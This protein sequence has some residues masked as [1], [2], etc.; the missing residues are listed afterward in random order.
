[1]GKAVSNAFVFVL[2]VYLAGWS[3]GVGAAQE[4]TYTGEVIEQAAG[5]PAIYKYIAGDKTKPLLVFVPG[6]HHTARVFYGGHQGY[7][8]EDFL[9]FWVNEKGYNFLALSY[10]IALSD[11]AIE[12]NHPDFTIR[13]WGK[14]VAALADK[15]IKGTWPAK[16]SY[17]NWLVD[18][19]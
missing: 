2:S 17:C 7:K 12:T 5:Y 6:A 19:R 9:A 4:H 16:S 13:D 18:G 15:T 11:P 10:P 8:A 14:Q 3:T 1:M